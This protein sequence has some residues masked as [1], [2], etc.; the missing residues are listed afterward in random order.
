MSQ[1]TS[2]ANSAGTAP[3]GGARTALRALQPDAAP[4]E[5]AAKEPPCLANALQEVTELHDAAGLASRFRTA[6]PSSCGGAVPSFEAALIA[7]EALHEQ[8]VLHN[9]PAVLR[10]LQDWRPLTHWNDAHIRALCGERTI[11]VR[12]AD[13][14]RQFGDPKRQGMYTHASLSLDSFIEAL[15]AAEARGQPAPYYAAQLS[16]RRDLPELFADTRPE[17]AHLHALGALWR[18]SPHLYIG[19]SSQTPLHFDAFDNLLCVVRGRKRLL[20]WPPGCAELLYPGGGGSALFS[21]ADVFA[22][23]LEAF[24]LLERALPLALHADL[25]PGDA[26]YLPCGWWH[27]VQSRPPAGQ[28]SISLSYLSLIHI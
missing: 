16:L 23:D 25:G 21:Q 6:D 18:G 17:P 27:A 7:P 10:A 20:L 9:R 22:P 8:F 4:P 13:S 28:R 26:L 12:V 19:G 24:P 15:E 5:R 14:A 11:D 1:L 2:R 3:R